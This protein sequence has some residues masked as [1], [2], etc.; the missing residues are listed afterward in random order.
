MPNEKVIIIKHFENTQKPN[1]NF[2]RKV[3][4][5]RQ[6]VKKVKPERVMWLDLLYRKIPFK[7]IWWVNLKEMGIERE[8]SMARG[9]QSLRFLE[10]MERKAEGGFTGHPLRGGTDD[11]S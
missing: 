8:Q 5:N 3:I 1:K 7:A 9:D 4:G 10:M 2:Q 6:L 11:G